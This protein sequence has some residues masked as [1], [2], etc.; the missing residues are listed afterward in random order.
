MLPSFTVCDKEFMPLFVFQCLPQWRR[1]AQQAC[2]FIEQRECIAQCAAMC[3][4]TLCG[5]SL[6]L[7][8]VQLRFAFGKPQPAQTIEEIMRVIACRYPLVLKN[9]K[10]VRSVRRQVL[11]RNKTLGFLNCC[12]YRFIFK[13]NWLA[14]NRRFKPTR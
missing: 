3:S 13:F 1:R 12:F 2:V 14:L 10:L 9:E 6:S 11:L 5:N 4:H 7:Q 8:A